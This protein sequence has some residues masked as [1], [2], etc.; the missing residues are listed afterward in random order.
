MI[1][2]REHLYE[3]Y[4]E[5]RFRISPNSFLQVNKRA[6]ES[7]IQS[8]LD[9]ANLND[10]TILLDIGSAMGIFSIFAS[11]KVKKVYAIDPS[12]SSID[13]GKCNAQ[14]NQSKDNIE[15]IGGFPEGNLHR[16]LKKISDLHSENSRIVAIVNP[17][18]YSLSKSNDFDRPSH[19]D[20]RIDLATKTTSILRS[21]QCLNE[22]FYILSKVDA[23]A[24]HNFYEL[25]AGERS[26]MKPM[27]QPLLPSMIY[28]VDLLPH[29]AHAESIV[30]CIR[31]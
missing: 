19:D 21:F 8:T 25:A 18:R 6:S 12:V 29:T 24:M 16:V 14:L 15:W 3:T 31:V 7:L 11:T 13:D 27:G 28:P 9:H 2:G 20:F 17:S 23:Q 4:Q 5:K 26:R 10:E 1:H 30:Q 22:I